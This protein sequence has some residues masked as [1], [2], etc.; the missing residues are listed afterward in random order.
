MKTKTAPIFLAFLCMGFGDLVGA[1]VGLLLPMV[2]GMYGAHVEFNPGEYSSFYVVLASILLLCAGATIL[3]L[4]G[5]PVMRDVSP[6]GAYS[7]NLSLAQSIKAVGS[8]LGF[9]VT[10]LVAMS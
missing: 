4:V 5:N 7:K 9:L 10:P 3:Q 6:E 1:L 2:N 8:S